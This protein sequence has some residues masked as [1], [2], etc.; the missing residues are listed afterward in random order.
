MWHN[1][2]LFGVFRILWL[3]EK[4]DIYCNEIGDE[5]VSWWLLNTLKIE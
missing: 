4:I 5:I 2:D 3:E 1:N